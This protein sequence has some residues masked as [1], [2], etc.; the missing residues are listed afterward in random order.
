[1]ARTKES[2]GT[3]EAFLRTNPGPMYSE[4]SPRRIFEDA[5]RLYSA[6]CA[7]PVEIGAF[8]DHL[9]GRGLTVE[10]VG[11]RYWLKLPGKERIYAKLYENSPTRISG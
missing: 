9:W 3:I 2:A 4:V 6:T 5:H 7:E 1:M 10:A 11:N 8:I